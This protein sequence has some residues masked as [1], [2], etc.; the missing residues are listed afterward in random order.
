MACGFRLDR[1]RGKETEQDPQ[2]AIDLQTADGPLEPTCEDRGPFVVMIHWVFSRQTV[3]VNSQFRKTEFKGA[4][5][6]VVKE[7]LPGLGKLSCC[8]N[9]NSLNGPYRSRRL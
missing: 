2:R 1:A 4:A 5:A 8:L 6:S 9:P 3:R 7:T